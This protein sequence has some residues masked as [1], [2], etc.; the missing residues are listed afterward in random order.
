M[1]TGI[2]RPAYFPNACFPTA[3]VLLGSGAA[4]MAAALP[5][6]TQQPQLLLL[7]QPS[8][9]PQLLPPSPPPQTTQIMRRIMIQVQL[10]PPKPQPQ[11]L[12]H[13]NISSFR[14]T[15][16]NIATEHLVL[17]V[18][19]PT[20]QKSFQNSGKAFQTML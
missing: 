13:I 14:F 1:P 15:V 17:Q 4:A 2:G 11:E 19:C 10:L 20:A 6:C 12:L 9:Q 16:H 8:P 7:P 3:L 5:F 18:F